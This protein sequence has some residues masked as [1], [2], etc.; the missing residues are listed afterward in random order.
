[1]KWLIELIKA[2]FS[3]CMENP[4]EVKEEMKDVGHKALENPDSIFTN[5]D[6]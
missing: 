5:S 3:V 2:F 1:V 6:W 4:I